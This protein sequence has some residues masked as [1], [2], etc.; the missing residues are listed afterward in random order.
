MYEGDS[1]YT[2]SAIGQVGLVLLSATLTAILLWF[3]VMVRWLR[4]PLRLGLAAL[5]FFGFVWLSPQVYYTYYMALFEGLPWQVVIKDKPSAQALWKLL[6][7]QGKATLSAHSQGV[8]GWVLIA[9]AVF[10]TG[11]PS[12]VSENRSPQDAKSDIP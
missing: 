9:I 12:G 1:F 4:L 5:L 10:R 6:T 3:V 7:F 8:V 11:K 2:L